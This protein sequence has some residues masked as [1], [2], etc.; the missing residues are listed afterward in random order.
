MLEEWAQY[1]AEWDAWMDEMEDDWSNYQ[2]VMNEAWQNMQ[3]FINNYFDNLDVQEEINNKIVSMIQSGEFGLLVNEYIPPAVNAWLNLNITQPTGVVID[4]SLTVAGA[5]ADAK[6]TGDAISNLKNDLFGFTEQTYNLVNNILP[7]LTV[8]A[9]GGMVDYGGTTDMIV[10][11]VTSGN[12]YTITTDDTSGFVG[13]FYNTTP[14][15]NTTASYDSSRIIQANKTFTAPITGYVAFRTSHNYATPQIVEGDKS[16][17]YIKPRTTID[18]IAR[19]NIS[20]INSKIDEFTELT[21]N[22]V[23]GKL[24]TYSISSSGQIGGNPYTTLWVAPI[25]QNKKYTVQSSGTAGLVYGF[26]TE[27]PLEDITINTYDSSRVVSTTPLYTI[28]APITGYIGFSSAVDGTNVQIIEGEFAKEYYPPGYTSIDYI[29]RSA[30]KGVLNGKILCCCGDSITYGADMDATGIAD[31]SNVPVYQSN[32]TGDFSVVSSNF[33][34]TWGFQ[35][36]NRNGMTFYNAGVS[37]STMQGLADKNGFS[38]ANGRYTKLPDNIDYLLI[39][40][41]WNDTAYGTLGS[42]TDTTNNS[43]YGGYN[44]VLPYLINKYPYA[45]IALIVPYGTDIGHRNAVRE[46]GS[47]WGVAV[48]DNYQ[49]GTPLYYGKEP[50]VGVEASV[51]TANQAKFQANGAHPNYKGH[52]QLADMIENWMRSL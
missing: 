32:E 14:T 28:T 2:E 5:C 22:L 46:L 41:G 8:D 43:F 31:S 23:K 9:S 18:I 6:A 29:A 44:V 15:E 25:E 20:A 49:G 11:P 24:E 42:I 35:I 1:Y 17:P 45:K 50:S 37:G 30:Y 36:A 27:N 16:K 51:V 12:I 34:K 4:T 19:N 40:F 21:Y 38:L 10:A 26:F 48:W 7:G 3:D 47:K 33:L 13:A 39:W 52:T